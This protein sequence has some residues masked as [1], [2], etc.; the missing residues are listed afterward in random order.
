MKRK[1][2]SL[3]L[4]LA[5][6]LGLAVPAL[7]A[8]AP[9]G[10]YDI[11]GDFSDGLAPVKR[12]GKWGYIDESG[13]EVV[14]CQY[15]LAGPFSGGVAVVSNATSD[16][17][18]NKSFQTVVPFGTYDYIW[19]FSDGMAIV[20]KND[21]QGYIDTA[22]KGVIPCRYDWATN[23]TNG[24]ATVI[25]NG[26]RITIDKTG[27]ET[28]GTPTTPAGATATPSNQTVNVDGKKVEF[29]MYALN[30]GGTNYIRVRDLAV[31][32]NG[33]AAQFEVGWNGNV[34]LTS[35]TPYTG[36]TEKAPFTAPE[37]YINYTAPTYVNGTAVNLEAIQLGGGGYTYY[38]LRDLGEAL[39]FNVGWSADKGVFIETDK[40][41][42]PND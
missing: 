8:N 30:G 23:F 16:A 19:Y 21:K 6:C 24:V 29:A 7:A 40:P 28:T 13:R 9:D 10:K 38:K 25:E 12:D 17:V 4:A 41:Y 37:P 18:I 20:M 11:V 3:F 27:K 1:A 39:G 5:L 22:G 34:V 26:K 15:R 14:S 33:T 32:L 31:I 36:D 42:N 2:L 35:K